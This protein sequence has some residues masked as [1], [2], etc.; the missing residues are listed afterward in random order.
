MQAILNKHLV[1]I[2]QSCFYSKSC[3]TVYV[4]LFILPFEVSYF[5]AGQDREGE[6]AC[7]THVEND[8]ELLMI[9]VMISILFQSILVG[10]LD[11]FWVNFHKIWNTPSPIVL[12]IYIIP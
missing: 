7:H 8:F 10:F 1:M 11:S 2:R 3:L 9:P 6:I 4:L 12:V 5:A